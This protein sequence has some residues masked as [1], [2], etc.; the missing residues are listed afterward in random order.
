MIIYSNFTP[1]TRSH[2]TEFFT[3]TSYFRP[4]KNALQKSIGL[5][6]NILNKTKAD[7]A[8]GRVG[9][10]ID[11]RASN[12]LG[13]IMRISVSPFAQQG[14][15]ETVVK[16]EQRTNNLRMNDMPPFQKGYAIID[17]TGS[18]SLFDADFNMYF[19]RMYF[20]ELWYN[21]FM[22]K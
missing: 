1:K 13:S 18:F 11:F 22:V 16:P 14:Y 21:C 20:G 17:P 7:T 3:P 4:R 2:F 10:G 6:S 15:V 12:L 5:I 9:R 8:R 19:A